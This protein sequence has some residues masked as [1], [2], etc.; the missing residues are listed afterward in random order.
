M[1]VVAEGPTAAGKTTW[2]ATLPA[3]HVIPE[4]GRIEVPATMSD[5]Q[6]ATFW[7]EVNCD[8]WSKSTGVESATGLAVCDTDPL[9][10]HYDYCLARIGA[11]AWARFERGVAEAEA[12]IEEQ[13][14]GVADLVVVRVPDDDTLARQRDSDQSRRRRNFELP[15]TPWP[16]TPGDIGHP[17]RS[18]V[19]AAERRHP[20]RDLRR[21]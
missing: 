9:K 16:P 19:P 11:A 18:P 4:T 20:L 7:N 6:H 10:L 13:R 1:I 21:R 8:R 2:A 15:R 3:Q 17:A 5:A 14:L 12:A